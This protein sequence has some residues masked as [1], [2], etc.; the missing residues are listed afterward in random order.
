MHLECIS[1]YNQETIISFNITSLIVVLKLNLRASLNTEAA[2]FHTMC[3]Y[4]ICKL[5]KAVK[6]PHGLSS[7]KSIANEH[8]LEQSRFVVHWLACGVLSLFAEYRG[9]ADQIHPF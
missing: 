2:F 6:L 3:S 7:F 9:L 8:L 1:Y 4:R 5:I